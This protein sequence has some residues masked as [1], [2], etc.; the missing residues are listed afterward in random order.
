MLAHLIPHLTNGLGYT[1]VQ[2]GLA[3]ALM[4]GVQMGGLLLGGILGDRYEKSFI[5]VLCIGGSLHWFA[6]GDL[7][8][9][10]DLDSWFYPVPWVCLGY[11]RSAHGGTTSRLLWS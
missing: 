8:Q 2:A 7:R 5:C 9:Q 4:T 1:P 6:D 10:S 11:S 3:F